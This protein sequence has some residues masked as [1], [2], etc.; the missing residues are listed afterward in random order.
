M[1]ATSVTGVGPG[2]SLG[3]QKPENHAGC[4]CKAP[5]KEKP[6]KKV[7]PSNCCV[8]IHNCGGKREITCGSRKSFRV[9][10]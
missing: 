8:V 3:K 5:A 10:R 2:D 6:A 9:C 7:L 1:A 4:G